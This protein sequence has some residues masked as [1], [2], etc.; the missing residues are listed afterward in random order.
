MTD[1][2]KDN[3]SLQG[4]IKGANKIL[5]LVIDIDRNGEQKNDLG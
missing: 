5:M 1:K 2:S 4:Y 3:P